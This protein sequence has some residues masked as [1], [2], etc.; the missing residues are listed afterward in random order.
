MDT[1]QKVAH[2]KVVVA[3]PQTGGEGTST[4]LEGEKGDEL[5]IVGKLEAAVLEHA[6]IKQHLGDDEI[7]IVIPKSLLLAAAKEYL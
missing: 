2:F 7:A 5:V 1:E 3:K 4:V 6:T